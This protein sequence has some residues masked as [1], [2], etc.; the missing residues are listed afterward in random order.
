M[1][2][3]STPDVVILDLSV[4]EGQYSFFLAPSLKQVLEDIRLRFSRK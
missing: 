3:Y 2:K 1:D 4:K